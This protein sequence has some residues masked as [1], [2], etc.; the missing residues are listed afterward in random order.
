METKTFTDY[1]EEINIQIDV[2]KSITNNLKRWEKGKNYAVS[3]FSNINI[4]KAKLVSVREKALYN[5]NGIISKF[6][7][8]FLANNGK[9]FI[10][11]NTKEVAEVLSR[12]I[13]E[14]NIEKVLLSKSSTLEEVDIQEFLN[15]KIS[16][17]K[18]SEFTYTNIGEHIEK[19]VKSKS[20]HMV[21]STLEYNIDE[22]LEKVKEKYTIED[23]ALTHEKIA[24]IISE[25]IKKKITDA[26]AVISGAHAVL[27]DTG[28]LVVLEN[29]GD[30]LKSSA[31]SKTHIII[32]GIDALF[33]QAKDMDIL[34]PMLSSFSLGQK[35]FTYGTLISPSKERNL[36]VIL[37]NNNRTEFLKN[38][39]LRTTLRCVK[40]G[41]CSNVC[42]VYKKVGGYAYD[43]AYPGPYG[44]VASP[45]M[46]SMKNYKHLPYATVL[47]GKCTEICP[48]NI[49]IHNNIIK[50]RSEI[51][52][53]DINAKTDISL[54]DTLYSK[55][56]K[57]RKMNGFN[58]AFKVF[59]YKRQ[60]R[61]LWGLQRELPEFA[62][63][64]F[65]K[66]YSDRLK[67]DLKIERKNQKNNEL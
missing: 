7:K 1:S 20:S 41:A 47:C 2:N 63:V 40:C 34:F 67:N 16:E 25:T 10:V 45:Y 13:K 53:K 36:Y 48:V 37:Y 62:K 6:E 42:P 57:R 35:M 49:D 66:Q 52:M 19:L 26:D 58:H 30:V 15:K 50:L 14:E 22:I 65:S 60:M 32:A 5:L 18:I 11:P 56:I 9:L 12:I 54:F 55:T 44:I 33:G 3:Q 29:E 43:N 38:N 17:K 59:K 39:N 28:S 4:A 27:A 24:Q 51:V 31:F 21:S 64:S 61:K 23:K 46:E 8:N